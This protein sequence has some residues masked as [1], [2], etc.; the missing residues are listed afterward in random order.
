LAR[1]T[2]EW[3]DET[4]WKAALDVVPVGEP[5]FVIDIRMDGV[6]EPR[7]RAVVDV[8]DRLP[9]LVY[10]A[11]PSWTTT[12]VRR[13]LENDSRFIVSQIDVASRGVVVRTPETPQSLETADLDR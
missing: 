4:R 12:F 5:P 7:A 11:R 6:M 2:H 9:V 3:G 10:D 1:A 8:S 13:A